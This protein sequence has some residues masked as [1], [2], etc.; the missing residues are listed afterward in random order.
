MSHSAHSTFSFNE[1]SHGFRSQDQDLLQADKG[2]STVPLEL[3]EVA[4]ESCELTLFQKLDKRGK[5]WS[6]ANS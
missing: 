6:S 2:K 1:Q 3:E 4:L 5:P